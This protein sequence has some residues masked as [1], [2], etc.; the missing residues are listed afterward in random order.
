MAERPVFKP[1]LKSDDF[2]ET[3][4]IEFQWF[5][6]FAVSQKQKSIRS[7]HEEAM[8]TNKVN[9]ILEISSKSQE[10]VGISASAFNLK[11]R[12]ENGLYASVESFYQGSKIFENGGP[13]IDLYQK[14]SLEAKTETRL[15]SSGDLKKFLFL[16]QEWEIDEHFYDWLY[17][18]ALIQNK[19]LAEKIIEYDAFTDIEF[20]PKRSFNCQAYT[21]AL[22]TAAIQRHIDLNEIKNPLRFKELFPK[23]KIFNF[24]LDLF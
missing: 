20:N 7:L 17:L 6:G 11:L 10:A 13:Y 23:E 18:N 14:S 3:I 22:Y 24:Q 9:K 19:D 5:A 15:K 8:A 16:E 1:T 21:A 12:T 2:V 4:N